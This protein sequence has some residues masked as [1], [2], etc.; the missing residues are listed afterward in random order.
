MTERLRIVLVHK[1]KVN[2]ADKLMTVTW[3]HI[4]GVEGPVALISGE[5]QFLISD[6]GGA[7]SVGLWEGR[8]RTRSPG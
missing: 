5:L 4:P 8:A 3:F 1:A 6:K 2:G 7:L